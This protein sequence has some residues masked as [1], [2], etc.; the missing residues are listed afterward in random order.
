VTKQWIHGVPSVTA[1]SEVSVG[2][3]PVSALF[4][5]EVSQRPVGNVLKS[6]LEFGWA[7]DVKRWSGTV[8]RRLVTP[9]TRRR[10]ANLPWSVFSPNDGDLSALVSL[11]DERAKDG[12]E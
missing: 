11:W 6:L 5:G 12:P 1:P 2:S 7:A 4:F 9:R 10:L 3:L 8:Q